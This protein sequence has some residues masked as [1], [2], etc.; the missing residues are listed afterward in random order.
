MQ[1]GSYLELFT[2]LYGWQ[3][4]DR[5][6][7]LL[8]GTGLA[9]LPFLG[10]V[11]NNVLETYGHG[12]TD[13][14][15]SSLRRMDTEIAVALTVVVLAGQPTVTLSAATLRYAAPATVASPTACRTGRKSRTAPCRRPWPTGLP[16]PPP[17]A[18][19]PT[20]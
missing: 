15:V 9:F 3:F 19:G 6:W 16:T 20:R 10:I 7:D 18:E 1:V 13:G 12:A 2:T 11:L 8:T 5:L 14:P 4:Y 17:R